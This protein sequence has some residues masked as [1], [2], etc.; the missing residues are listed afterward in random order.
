MCRVLNLSRPGFKITESKR[1]RVK[2]VV[3]CLLTG[4]VSKRHL[5]LLH[6]VLMTSRIPH[7]WE[8][9]PRKWSSGNPPLVSLIT[10]DKRLRKYL[11]TGTWLRTSYLFQTLDL[12]F[13]SHQDR[14][15]RRTR[16]S[17]SPVH[18]STTDVSGLVGLMTIWEE[19]WSEVL[20]VWTFKNFEV[21]PGA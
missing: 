9:D 2:R 12:H 7:L 3:T 6:S 1:H 8:I 16:F 11:V 18:T 13:P 20:R 17:G 5:Y 14:Y 15:L 21:H 4:Q 19:L 10:T